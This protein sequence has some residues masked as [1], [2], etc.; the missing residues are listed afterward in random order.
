MKN[1]GTVRF[2]VRDIFHSQVFR[3]RSQ[4]S[5][6]D[7]EIEQ[8]NETRVASIAFSYRF[9]KG[10]KIAPVKRTAGSANEEQERI[11]NQ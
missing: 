2:T 5:N 1:Q 3:G 11:G 6:V 7:F 10:K 4:Y 9:A 8:V